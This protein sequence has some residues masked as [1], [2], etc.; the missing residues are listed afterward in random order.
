MSASLGRGVLAKNA[1]TAD[2]DAGEGG[3]GVSD[4]MLTL[5]MLGSG[6]LGII[7]SVTKLKILYHKVQDQ[8]QN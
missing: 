1:D 4:K 5:L 8:T 2:A 7:S 6:G 3:W